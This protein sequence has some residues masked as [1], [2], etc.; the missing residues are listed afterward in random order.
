MFKSYPRNQFQPVPRKRDGFFA[1]DY[2]VY[3]LRN[4]ADRHYIGFT[5]NVPHRVSQHND[6][7]SNWTRP[8]GPWLLVWTSQ[9]LSLSEARKLENFL[10]RQKGGR[11][12]Y[13]FTGLIRPGS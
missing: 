9:P 3:V 1:L 4:S 6:G 7:V 2:F 12:F 10:K 8:R 11:G 13:N 5:E